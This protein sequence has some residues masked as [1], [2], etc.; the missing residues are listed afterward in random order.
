MSRYRQ[1]GKYILADFFTAALA[2][3]LFNIC[4]YADL[5][6]YESSDT[7]GEFLCYPQVLTGQIC[8]PFFWLIIYYF[9]GY[10]NLPLSRNR[11]GELWQ[12]LTASIIGVILIFFGL[13]LD[14]IPHSYHIYYHFLFKMFCFHFGLTYL[15]RHCLT[16]RYLKDVKEGKYA[17]RVMLLGIDARA[18]Q[19]GE[20]LERIDYRI[21]GFVRVDEEERSAV[22]ENRRI[23][24]NAADLPHLLQQYP[25]DELVVATEVLDGAAM[26]QFLYT[27][28]RYKKPI[29]VWI[30]KRT[31][32][33]S[34][35]RSGTISGV[36]LADITEN[37]FS[38]AGKNIKL[39]FD[40]VVSVCV[41]LFLS[42]VYLY[43]AWRVKRDSPGPVIYKQERIGY[44]GCPFLIY[45]FHTMYTSAEDEGPMLAREDDRRVTP[46]GA[47]LRK[48]RLDELPQFSNVLKGDMSLVR[49][50]PERK[51]FIDQIVR[52]AH[53]YYLLHNV[54]PGITSLGMVKYGY[55]GS[56]EQM[57][58]RLEYDIIYYENM[59]LALEF[60]ILAYTIRTVIMG[61]GV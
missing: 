19:I 13:V 49:P 5:V 58:R 60:A 57:L 33:F 52:H 41:L 7:L 3:L 18:R 50:R 48:Y 8:I 1:I 2:W 40:K 51:Y 46:F 56:I 28:Y 17:R 14:E 35:V 47:F 4:R 39:C 34:K 43:I 61:K 12:T 42:P 31:V 9:S 24:K 55:A 54:R 29:K 15:C 11:I 36:P 20:E 53:Y 26:S 6:V 44:R 22:P 30:D 10:Y 16:T 32:P 37:N 21:V 45:K 59:S 27:L 23:G 25:V 38:P